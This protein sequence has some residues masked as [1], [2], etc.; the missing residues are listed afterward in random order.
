MKQFEPRSNSLSTCVFLCFSI[1]LITEL[2]CFRAEDVKLYSLHPENLVKILVGTK[3]K[4]H[5]KREVTQ[6]KAQELANNLDLQ[7]MEVSLE[8]NFNISELFEKLT[9]EVVKTFQRSPKVYTDIK[10]ESVTLSKTAVQ[11]PKKKEFKCSC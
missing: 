3:S 9:K 5:Q 8:E 2:F 11:G 7:Y 4:D 10:T 1:V 6:E